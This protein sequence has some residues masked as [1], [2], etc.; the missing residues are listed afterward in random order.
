MFLLD[1]RLLLE[2]L[3][4]DELLDDLTDE[5]DLD[6]LL[7][8]LIVDD[9]LDLDDPLLTP[10]D[11]LELVVVLGLYVDE[12]LLGLV[13]VVDLGR[14]LVLDLGLTDS[15]LTARLLFEVSEEV[16]LVFD[17]LFVLFATLL[18]RF[19]AVALLP[20][21]FPRLVIPVRLDAYREP[22]LLAL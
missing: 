16:I 12:L 9:D 3:L 5:E 6:E 18:L 2:L 20:T 19:V 7:D 13:V 1:P 11:L 15:V 22:L 21:T 17:D 14:V 4:L 10:D 8:L